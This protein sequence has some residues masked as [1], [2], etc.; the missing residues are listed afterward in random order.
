[1]PSFRKLFVKPDNSKGKSRLS[2]SNWEDTSE[3]IFSKRHKKSE[4]MEKRIVR[5]DRQRQRELQYYEYLKQKEAL[6]KSNQF[7]AV[8]THEYKS[9]NNRSSGAL[10]VLPSLNNSN[11]S[12]KNNVN[13]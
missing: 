2:K 1:M 8:Y 4:D 13:L 5:W 10:S 3:D 7:A 11:F 6:K 9:R 12:C